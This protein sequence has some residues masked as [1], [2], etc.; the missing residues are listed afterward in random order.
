VHLEAPE[1]VS[2]GASK[3]WFS[4]W[5]GTV[6]SEERE[7]S[8]TLE[9]NSVLTAQSADSGNEELEKIIIPGLDPV[10]PELRF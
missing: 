7:L 3:K 10:I 9:T 4:H 6:E 1:Y 8:V 2:S 5:S